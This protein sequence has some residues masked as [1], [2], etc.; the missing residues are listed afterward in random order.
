MPLD[1]HKPPWMIGHEAYFS[2]P[3]GAEN[4]GSEPVFPETHAVFLMVRRRVFRCDLRVVVLGNKVGESGSFMSHIDEDARAG[5]SDHAER[6][7][8]LPP[9]PALEDAEDVARPARGLNPDQ[10]CPLR[11]DVTQQQGQMLTAVDDAF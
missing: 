2:Q 5:L 11:I 1:P 7:P 9:R 6:G 10:G 4:L 8:Q 3:Q